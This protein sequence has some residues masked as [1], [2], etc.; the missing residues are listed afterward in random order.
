MAAHL[1][2]QQEVQGSVTPS[3]SAKTKN[4]Q[5]DGTT[6][7]C[8]FLAIIN[9][10]RR[11]WAQKELK[12]ARRSKEKKSKKYFVKMLPLDFSNKYDL[13]KASS[14]LLYIAF[15]LLKLIIRSSESKSN[16]SKYCDDFVSVLNL[17]I[18]MI[19][20]LMEILI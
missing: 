5:R 20:F 14:V 8:A 13:R 19:I 17:D 12:R 11:V 10:N 18:S 1:A 9:R 3:F 4:L 15:N 16:F 7:Y 2:A 6:R